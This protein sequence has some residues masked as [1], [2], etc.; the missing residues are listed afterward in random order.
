MGGEEPDVRVVKRAFEALSRRD[1]KTLLEVAARDVEFLA[2]KTA[3]LARKGRSYHGHDG[4]FR[5]MRDVARVWEELEL[6][7]HRYCSA[8]DGQV[9]VVGRVRARG[10]GG[11]IV[12]E[13]VSWLV[14]VRDGKVTES[15]PCSAA[16]A[17][18]ID[19]A[20]TAAA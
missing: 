11:Y 20:E 15:R 13:G 9:L 16:E 12:D 4:I 10:Q 14:Q 6:I 2:P 19:V 18:A 7:P 5:Y 3:T 8:G 1:V 17:Q